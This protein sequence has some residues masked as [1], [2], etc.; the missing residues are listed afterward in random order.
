MIMDIMSEHTAILRRR[1]NAW[2]HFLLF[3]N[4]LSPE[5]KVNFKSPS[6][7]NKGRY[8]IKRRKSS[9]S[10]CTIKTQKN[11]GSKSTRSC[12][13]F[14]RLIVDGQEKYGKVEIKMIL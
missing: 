14:R 9:N 12:K 4:M 11:L 7:D 5:E 8:C 1:E 3:R 10:Y 2:E 13:R 6:N